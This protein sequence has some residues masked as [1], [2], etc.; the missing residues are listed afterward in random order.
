[1]KLRPTIFNEIDN[2]PNKNYVS[3]CDVVFMEDDLG[4]MQL[5]FVNAVYIDPLGRSHKVV[6]E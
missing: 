6:E 5:S 1:M 2:L 4:R 3:D